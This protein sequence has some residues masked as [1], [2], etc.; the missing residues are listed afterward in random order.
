MTVQ[1]PAR[2]GENS[3]WRRHCCSAQLRSTC[4]SLNSDTNFENLCRSKRLRFFL[5]YCTSISCNSHYLF[6][7][8]TIT[9]LRRSYTMKLLS[10][11]AAVAVL[12]GQSQAL[13]RYW[14]SNG[15]CDGS[16]GVG[17]TYDCG[18]KFFS[19]YESGSRK[20][21]TDSDSNT[22]SNAFW[23]DGGLTPPK[24]LQ[25]VERWRYWIDM[26]VVKEVMN[27]PNP[28]LEDVIHFV[29]T[30]DEWMAASIINME[31]TSRDLINGAVTSMDEH[32]TR[33]SIATAD[34]GQRELAY[35]AL[36]HLDDMQHHADRI[37]FPRINLGIRFPGSGNK[38]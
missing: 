25:T 4:A 23:K 5:G 27:R 37:N 24:Y 14:C 16:P 28:A 36:E 11:A 18:N 31:E 19:Y 9:A 29:D 32:W 8:F 38:A 13:V 15:A 10:V 2:I 3:M 21:W 12:A 34:G 6:S 17:P 20:K 22:L 35:T 33:I 1:P 26:P 7:N 30:F